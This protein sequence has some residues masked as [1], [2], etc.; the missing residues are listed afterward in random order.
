MHR[1]IDDARKIDPGVFITISPVK[2]V[3]GNFKRK[4]IA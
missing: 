3:V 4:T 2:R 1:V